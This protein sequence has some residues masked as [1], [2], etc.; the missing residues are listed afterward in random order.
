MDLLEEGR[1]HSWNAPP[2][3]LCLHLQFKCM[4]PSLFI[5]YSYERVA[6]NVGIM[7]ICVQMKALLILL[8]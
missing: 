1:G 2:P 4:R 5:Y 3:P 7:N 6:G 8:K